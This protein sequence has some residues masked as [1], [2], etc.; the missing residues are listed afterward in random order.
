MKKEKWRNEEMR[1]GCRS[2]KKKKTSIYMILIPVN[3]RYI[4][5][6][7]YSLFMGSLVSGQSYSEKNY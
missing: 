6:K 3:S 1:N 7:I 2:G 5:F 4:C